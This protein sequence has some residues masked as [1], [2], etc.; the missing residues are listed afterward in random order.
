[1]SKDTIKMRR[2]SCNGLGKMP[3]PKR[4]APIEWLDE[5]VSTIGQGVVERLKDNCGR[6][7]WSETPP[8]A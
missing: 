3:P 7:V 6:L 5:D 2:G 8:A 1:M 4:L